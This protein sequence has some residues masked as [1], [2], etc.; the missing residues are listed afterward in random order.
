MAWGMDYLLVFLFGCAVGAAEL[1]SRHSDHRLRAMMT[2][3]SLGYLFL[4]GI[5][6]VFTLLVVHLAGPDGQCR[7]VSRGA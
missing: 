3:P 5:L 4:N 2:A 1:V 6:S 7:E